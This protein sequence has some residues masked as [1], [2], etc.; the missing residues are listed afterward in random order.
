[1][2]I[3]EGAKLA[4][5]V[6]SLRETAAAEESRLSKFR[7]ESVKKTNEDIDALVK[8]RV[9]LEK[10]VDHLKEQKRILRIPLDEEWTLATNSAESSR[11]EE[12]RLNKKLKDLESREI[13]IDERERGLII[14]ESRVEDE[15]V[16]ADMMSEEIAEKLKRTEE[17]F[18]ELE[19]RREMFSEAVLLKN[20]ELFSRE[21]VVAAHERDLITR[22][23]VLVQKQ[24]E[25]SDKEKQVN[26]KYATLLR[27]E[28]RLKKHV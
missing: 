1:M 6:D 22:E 11:L 12:E 16:R 26:D 13:K 18:I 15:K 4:R 8:R 7:I 21:A 17:V 19:D 25:L 5:K 27:T 14:E 24:K 9:V 3:N 2:E 10:E 23:D 20:N 28:Q